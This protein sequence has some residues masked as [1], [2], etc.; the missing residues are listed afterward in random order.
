MYQH[1]RGD[2]DL[3]ARRIVDEMEAQGWHVRPPTHA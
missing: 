1:A 2:P 3:L